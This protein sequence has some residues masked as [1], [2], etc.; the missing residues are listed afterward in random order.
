M[1]EIVGSSQELGLLLVDF[2]I[3]EIKIPEHM[4]N[5][6]TTSIPL[7][8]NSPSTFGKEKLIHA[9]ASTWLP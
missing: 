5:L 8:M 6:I 1:D 2:E 7:W 3:E 9:L 4:N